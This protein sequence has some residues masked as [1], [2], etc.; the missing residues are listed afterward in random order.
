MQHVP[1][2]ARIHLEEEALKIVDGVKTTLRSLCTFEVPSQASSAMPPTA[3]WIS[4]SRK[5]FDRFYIALQEL[6]PDARA[7]LVPVLL[8]RADSQRIA[9]ALMNAVDQAC[10][11]IINQY[12]KTLKRVSAKNPTID[13]SGYYLANETASN[14]IAETKSAV[15]AELASASQLAQSLPSLHQILVDNLPS[16]SGEKQRA[17]IAEARKNSK[18][19]KLRPV[20][21]AIAKHPMV[22][23][24]V[25]HGSD[26]FVD[27]KT[28]SNIAGIRQVYDQTL[29]KYLTQFAAFLDAVIASIPAILNIFE[30]KA[31][32]ICVAA[33][34]EIFTEIVSKGGTVHDFEE[35]ETESHPP[36]PPAPPATPSKQSSVDALPHDAASP[37]ARQE[38][39]VEQRQTTQPESSSFVW[40]LVMGAI[41]LVVLAAAAASFST[42]PDSSSSDVASASVTEPSGGASSSE[43]SASQ[44]TAASSAALV[45]ASQPEETAAR[46][47]DAAVQGGPGV[48]AASASAA[49]SATDLELPQPLHRIMTAVSEGRLA[50]VN[51][52]VASIEMTNTPPH[53]DRVA[54]RQLN[55]TG[56]SFLNGKNYSAA[57]NSF[58][59]GTSTDPADPEILNNLAY[60]YMLAGDYNKA[61]AALIKTLLMSPQRTSAWVNLGQLYALANNPD[62][63]KS[64]LI[65]GYNFSTAKPEALQYFGKLAQNTSEP[66][67]SAAAEAALAYLKGI[68]V[69]PPAASAPAGTGSLPA[70]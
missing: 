35:S 62:E 47:P 51:A 6:S 15:L 8:E 42:R 37:E 44:P 5:E 39:P 25:Q 63:A 43:D 59:L 69:S 23:I 34:L 60:A 10:E 16:Y 17:Q 12:K 67:V 13:L 20:L 32:S 7:N 21:T 55:T 11:K 38:Q 53:G 54:A 27:A 19:R 68:N 26:I 52:I 22:S 30:Q 9:S 18:L 14:F 66:Q 3:A 36:E 46:L 57:I 33:P 70:Q 41:A 28:E 31:S 29:F 2:A 45:A 24:A 61:K 58:S 50:E 65:T 49:P 64:A 40:A 56:L 4:A 48:T 1:I